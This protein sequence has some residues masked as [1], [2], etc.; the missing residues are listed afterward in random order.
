MP[1]KKEKINTFLLCVLMLS[2]QQL[3][4][5]QKQN[6][7]QTNKHHHQQEKQMWFLHTFYTPFFTSFEIAS[8]GLKMY[9]NMKRF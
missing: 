2:P 7:K 8:F 4:K 3:W 5:K 1:L 9:C 6:Q